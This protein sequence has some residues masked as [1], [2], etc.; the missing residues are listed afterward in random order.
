MIMS[1][2]D[3][4][5][6]LKVI[7]IIK[8]V[9]TIIKIVVPILLIVSIM[10]DL[11]G[12]VSSSNVL[13]GIG[14]SITRKIVAA[15]LIFMIPS[16]VNLIISTIDGSVE[17]KTCFEYATTENIQAKYEQHMSSLMATIRKNPTMENYSSAKSYLRNISDNS[18]KDKYSNELETLKEQI[19]AKSQVIDNVP[20]SMAA[21]DFLTTAKNVWNEVVN[22]NTHFTY[23]PTG[24]IPPTT[25]KLDCSGLVSWVLYE[26]GYGDFKGSQEHT[27]N[28]YHT[29]WNKR[30]G[31]TEIDVKAGS[32]VSNIVQP[33][34]IV[35]RRGIKDG[36]EKGHV[37]IIYRIE[38]KTIYG[39]D[40]G[41]SKAINHGAYPNGYRVNWFMK[42]SRPGKIIRV[43]P[44]SK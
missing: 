23:G 18:L 40:A 11:M 25:T 33:G 30:Y 39:F 10:V 1:I 15:I 27:Y 16:F 31:W 26:Y 5:D 22:G 41:S 17:Y 36:E 43:T 19:E 9:I 4:P 28:F 38:G 3:V 8:T 37:D 13:D 12:N 42:D 24:Q 35:V 21:A 32:D 34:D 2:C 14:K 6:A 20:S 44:P 29:N 7:R